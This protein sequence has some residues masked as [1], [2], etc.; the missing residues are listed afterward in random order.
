MLPA[1]HVHAAFL[2]IMKPDFRDLQV[3]RSCAL[4]IIILS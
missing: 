2:V 3:P 4:R 1:M